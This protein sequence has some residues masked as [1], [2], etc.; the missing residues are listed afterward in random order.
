MQRPT[1]DLEKEFNAGGIYFLDARSLEDSSF[2]GKYM[3]VEVEIAIPDGTKVSCPDFSYSVQ[4]KR[5]VATYMTDWNLTTVNEQKCLRFLASMRVPENI[6]LSKSLPT[7]I[8]WTFLDLCFYAGNEAISEDFEVDTFT[9]QRPDTKTVDLGWILPSRFVDTV[10][11]ALG[12]MNDAVLSG[13]LEE[14]ILYGVRI[15]K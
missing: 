10:I 15:N 7:N 5:G 14:A 1:N 3:G 2:E 12:K 8:A 13:M 11:D 4:N 9:K 6:N